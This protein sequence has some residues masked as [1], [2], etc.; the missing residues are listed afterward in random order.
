MKHVVQGAMRFQ[1]E[2]FYAQE[3]LFNDLAGTQSPEVLFITCADSRI[4]PSLI[5][6]TNPGDLFVCRNAGN[7]VPPH[8]QTGEGMTGSI[9][10]AVH[11]LGV[12]HIVV[13]GHSD[14][15]AMKGRMNMSS[16]GELPHVADWLAHSRAAHTV[17][18]RK[19]SELNE[20]EQL[21]RLIEQNV[22]LQLQHLATHPYIAARLATNDIELHGWVYDIGKGGINVWDEPS[23][24]FRPLAEQY[25]P[26]L[27]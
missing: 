17:V 14:C 13:C 21:N 27:D 20:A 25:Q 12:K 16:L 26:M 2:G 23:D 24:T 5:T 3:K 19:F 18:M 15:G 9:E 11:A 1:N 10:Y 8:S 7:I 22:I 4:D 6:E